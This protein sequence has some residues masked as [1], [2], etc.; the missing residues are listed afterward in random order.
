M[1]KNGQVTL[2]VVLIALG[3]LFLTANFLDI[4]VGRIF[5]PTLLVVVG[6]VLIFRPARLNA[7]FRPFGLERLGAWEV[8]NEELWMFVGEVELDYTQA[9]L[10]EGETRL[11]LGAFVADTDLRIPADVGVR[12]VT[13][14]FV[15]DA[16]VNGD[17]TDYIF[18][19]LNYRSENYTSAT[20]KLD[21]ELSGFVVSLKVRHS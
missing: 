17:E 2:A 14:A 18:S 1:E 19:G 16:N 15:T 7:M 12:L 21:I 6:L 3:A 5:W 11:R 10:P 8:K 20:R 9:Q 4:N 13:S